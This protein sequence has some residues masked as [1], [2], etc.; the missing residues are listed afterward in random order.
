MKQMGEDPWQNIARRYP[1]GTRVFGKVKQ[2]ELIMVA[3]LK[4]KKALRV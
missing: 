2:S 1:A 4:L 3:L